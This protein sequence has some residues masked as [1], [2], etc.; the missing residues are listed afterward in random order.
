[1]SDLTFNLDGTLSRKSKT[2]CKRCGATEICDDCWEHVCDWSPFGVWYCL[3]CRM[4][5]AVFDGGAGPV[6][7]EFCGWDEATET[8]TVT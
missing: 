4:P 1:M 2:P 3:L 6:R 5:Q 7:C 8:T